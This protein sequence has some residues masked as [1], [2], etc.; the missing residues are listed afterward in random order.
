[1]KI[2]LISFFQPIAYSTHVYV[3]LFCSQD[4]NDEIRQEQMWE[5]HILNRS[6]SPNTTSNSNNKSADLN[7]SV[8]GILEKSTGEL[9]SNGVM[10]FSVNEVPVQGN[11]GLPK[12]GSTNSALVNNNS[13]SSSSSNSSSGANNNHNTNSGNNNNDNSS[14]NNNNNLSNCSTSSSNGS[15]TPP[16]LSNSALPTPILISHPAMRGLKT[17][18]AAGIASPT[19]SGK[20]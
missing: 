12:N 8:G 20:T 16:E 11:S 2:V 13:S 15:L 1:M 14:N 5:M 7:G 3:W 9:L 19:L 17:K 6:S 4:Y 10:T 18:S